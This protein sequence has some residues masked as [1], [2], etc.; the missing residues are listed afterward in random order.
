MDHFQFHCLYDIFSFAKP[1]DE[2][3]TLLHTACA[4]TYPVVQICQFVSPLFAIVPLLQFLQDPDA[5]LQ[6]HILSLIQL[7]LQNVA[8]RILGR[9]LYKFLIIIDS[10]HIIFHLNRQFAERIADRPSA[11]SSLISQQKH[12]S[13]ILVTSVNLIQITDGA[14]HHH[15][16][17]PPPING[18]RN[19]CGLHIFSLGNQILYFI[20]SY[21]IFILIQGTSLPLPNLLS[22][23]LS[24][25]PLPGNNIPL[26]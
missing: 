4:K 11:G 6:A 22:Q 9:H 5:F 14:K 17:H 16:L 10:R 15:A 25:Y 3:I 21:F 20:R 7:I 23:L 24:L 1:E 26:F 18:I 12:I 8:S 19:L 13:G 2:L